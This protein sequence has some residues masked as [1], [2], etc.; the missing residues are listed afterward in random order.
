MNSS[1][2]LE[3]FC[4]EIIPYNIA[5]DSISISRWESASGKT[6]EPTFFKTSN[7]ICFDEFD[8]SDDIFELKNE[9][10]NSVS[11]S[12]KIFLYNLYSK[13]HHI[14]ENH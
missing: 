2:F 10:P 11:K 6:S 13:G 8:E 14:R 7:L 1:Y 5:G 12:F 4:I 3:Q 9:G